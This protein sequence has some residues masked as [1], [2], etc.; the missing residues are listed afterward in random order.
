MSRS[1]HAP[2]HPKHSI[3]S[4]MH[5]AKA[6][7][8]KI[9]LGEQYYDIDT[10]Q[11]L[12]QTSSTNDIAR[13]FEGK[14]N[15]LIISDLQLSGRGQAGRVWQSPGGNLYLS[16]LASLHHAVS[17]RLALEVALGLSNIP[18]LTGIHD[19][20]IKWPNDLYYQIAKGQQAKWGGILI[21]PLHQNQVIIGVGIN[22]VPMQDQVQDQSV[23]DLSS[24][25]GK[26]VDRF[27][28]AYQVTQALFHACEHFDHGSFQLATRFAA[29]DA[30]LEQPVIVTQAGQPDIQGEA[31]G[32]QA[33]GA[34]LINAADRQHVIYSGHVR[35]LI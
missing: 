6:E 2:Q 21:E 10:V 27:E 17:G 14:G 33:D 19:I 8:L 18:M 35:P 9:Q 13:Q 32:I 15:T 34:L 29:F 22:L 24:I 16:L 12:E 30:L 31:I 4:A 11:W 20:Q 26:P 3:P 5:Q 25:M 7:Q 1:H 28:L 23:T